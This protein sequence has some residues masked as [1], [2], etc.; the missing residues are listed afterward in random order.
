MT[1]AGVAID[2]A[3]MGWMNF[4]VEWPNADRAGRR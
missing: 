1:E 2:Y 3:A 4:L